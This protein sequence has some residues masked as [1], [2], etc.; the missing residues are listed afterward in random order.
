M[1]TKYSVHT[2]QTQI[3][4]VGA[5]ERRSSECNKRT[6]TR[7]SVYSR[8]YQTHIHHTNTSYPTNS[9]HFWDH[10]WNKL[11]S[12]CD[13]LGSQSGNKIVLLESNTV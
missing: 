9:N 4:G 10:F 7:T 5:M 6:H 12:A 3:A 1:Q 13:I 11:I 8:S 2:Y